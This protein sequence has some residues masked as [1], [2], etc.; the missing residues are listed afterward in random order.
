M[1][2]RALGGGRSSAWSGTGAL[3]RRHR[4]AVRRQLA[5]RLAEPRGTAE[6]RPRDGAARSEPPLLPRRPRS[7]GIAPCGGP[8]DVG[9]GPRST[10]TRGGG[11][12]PEGRRRV[13]LP[14]RLD[15]RR[16]RCSVLRRARAI[17]R[18]QG[19]RAELDPRP[20][21]VFRVWMDA[22]TV[23]SGEYVEVEPPVAWSSPGD[24]RATSACRRARPRSSSRSM[25]TA[26]AR[27]VAPP[28]GLPDGRRR[29]TTR[30]GG[31]SSRPV[32]PWRRRGS[33]TDA[34]EPPPP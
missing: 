13:E 19:V 18:W 5:R 24:G 4:G 9:A 32:S 33:G 11:A 3:G 28:D 16:R 21:G 7:A 27:S 6:G 8:G 2:S 26:T 25:R 20:G 15:A 1:P 23:A 30:R 34:G 22:N 12:I 10:P 17:R 29:R 31:A 14:I